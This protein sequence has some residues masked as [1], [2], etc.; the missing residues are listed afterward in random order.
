MHSMQR[1][2]VVTGASSGIGAALARHLGGAGHRVVLAARREDALKEVASQSGEGA[3][4]VT[5][6]VRRR[7]DVARI[8]DQAI[9]AFG[10]VDVWVNNAGRGISRPVLEL[11]DEEFDEM[12][13]VNVKS[14]LYGM[15]AIVPHFIERG[16]G[17]V[18]NVSSV[19]GRV[20][21]A[22]IRSAYSASK[23]ALNSLTAN[24]RVDLARYPGIHVT[25]VMPGMV[26]TDFGR[27]V[28][29]A[30]AGAGAA[31][32]P[33]PPGSLPPGVRPQTPEQVVAVIAEAIERPVAEVFTN[34]LSAD[35]MREY[36]KDIG[37]FEARGR[38]T[39]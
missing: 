7:E 35:L 37:A 5:A 16:S 29:G 10:H 11:T 32:S 26:S 23:A 33:P 13:L 31:G 20:P 8:R 39:S 22:T 19:L 18:I 14:A 27:S 9:A 6:D 3:R 28:I 36:Y 15:Q 1:I 38:P 12:M 24:A 25:L 17:Q 34:P 4:V 2:A 21:M 30:G